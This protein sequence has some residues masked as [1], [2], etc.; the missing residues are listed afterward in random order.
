M[1]NDVAHIL[2][3]DDSSTV[4]SEVTSKLLNLRVQV[5]EAE[6]GMSAVQVLRAE[7]IDLA[8]IDLKMPFFDGYDLLC[9]IRGHDK[10]KHLPVL[11]LTSSDDQL[12]ISRA[13]ESGATAYLVKPLNWQAFGAH[14]QH[15]LHLHRSAKGCTKYHN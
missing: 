10:L 15:L 3:V 11:V 12:S 4:R 14:V 5:T 8:I 13:L 7:N 1:N 9:F 2:V 6:D